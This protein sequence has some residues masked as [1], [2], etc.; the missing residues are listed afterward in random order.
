MGN[1]N[2]ANSSTGSWPAERPHIVGDIKRVEK[3]IGEL[4][5]EIHAVSER[6]T[7]LETRAVQAGARAGAIASVIVAAITA[8]SWL[9]AAL[10]KG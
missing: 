10:L 3:S 2:Q 4:Y 5:K 6:V 9:V 8:A 1:A 7:R